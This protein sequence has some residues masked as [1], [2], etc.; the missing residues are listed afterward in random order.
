M[1]NNVQGEKTMSKQ[2]DQNTHTTEEGE[3]SEVQNRVRTARIKGGGSFGVGGIS[4]GMGGGEV[5]RG[6]KRRISY[7]R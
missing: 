7:G 1:D 2:V 4:K 3:S 5:I 6:Y